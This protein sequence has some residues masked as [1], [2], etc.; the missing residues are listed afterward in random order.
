MLLLYTEVFTCKSEWR[1]SISADT[2]YLQLVG[3]TY[4]DK[5][6]LWQQKMKKK[7][8][9]P[10]RIVKPDHGLSESDSE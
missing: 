2:C 9:R 1:E 7:F 3:M 6:S 8:K 4:L 5:A 10:V